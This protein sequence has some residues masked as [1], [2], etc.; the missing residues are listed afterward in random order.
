MDKVFYIASVLGTFKTVLGIVLFLTMFAVVSLCIWY[1]GCDLYAPQYSDDSDRK[2]CTK[3]LKRSFIALIVSAILLIFVPGRETY[4]F[5]VGGKAVEKVANNEN[6]Q[7]AAEKTLNLL[8]EYIE[9]KTE[10][11]KEKHNKEK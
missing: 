6:I 11:V 1:F 5:M 7:G 10:E 3:W 4:L 2:A 9:Y 8:N